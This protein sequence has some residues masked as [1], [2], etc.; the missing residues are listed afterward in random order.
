MR[1]S[2]TSQVVALG[3]IGVLLVSAS[4]ADQ[5]L[6]PR[7]TQLT[8]S[9][10]GYSEQ[11]TEY[12]AISA[13]AQTWSPS[14]ER[15]IEANA[16]EM[17]Q[18]RARLGRLG[19]AEAD[20]RTADFQFRPQDDPDDDDGDRAEGFAVNHKMDVVIRDTEKLGRVLDALARGG[21]VELSVNRYWGYTGEVNPQAL[22]KARDLAIDDARRKADDYADALGM[23]VRRVVWIK[24]QSAHVAD[25]PMHARIAAADVETRIDTRPQTVL[26]SVGMEFELVR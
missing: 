10:Q 16:A 18:L 5:G 13:T 19:I 14:P 26:A 22:R 20:F 8:V 12:V 4:A 15:A 17:Q 11:S 21:A 25:R 7:V 9:G 23:K 1:F 2:R 6:D 24:D 3:A